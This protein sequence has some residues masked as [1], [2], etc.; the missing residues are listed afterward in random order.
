[1]WIVDFYVIKASF[2]LGLY[3]RFQERSLSLHMTNIE[4][5]AAMN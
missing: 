4:I 5:L 3:S 2:D 1:M